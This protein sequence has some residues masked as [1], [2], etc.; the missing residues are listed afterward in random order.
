VLTEA[1]QKGIELLS[2]NQDSFAYA[3]SYDEAAGRFRGLVFGKML[4]LAGD[5]SSGV[6]VRADA[7]L[8]QAEKEIATARPVQDPSS[9]PDPNRGPSA[10][11]G[12][13]AS[14]IPPKKRLAT[15]FR[16]SVTLDSARVGRDAGCI[17]DEIV[18]H[19]SGLVGSNVRVVLE[20]EA[21]V[22]DGATDEIVRIVTENARSLKFDSQ[23]FE[24][25]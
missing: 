4:M 20:I 15:R 3:D 24:S 13:E 21:S 1:V 8:R 23:G 10:V 18:S 25:E 2:W 9:P 6:I 7:A 11:E 5:A 12:D 17:A 16:G 19:L 22:P 14:R